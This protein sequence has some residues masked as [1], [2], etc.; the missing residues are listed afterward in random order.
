VDKADIVRE[1]DKIG[2]ALNW[3]IKREE[4][5]SEANAAQHCSDKILYSPLTTKLELAKSAL[6]KLSSELLD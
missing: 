3:A 2:E 6:V 5:N 1:L 4:G